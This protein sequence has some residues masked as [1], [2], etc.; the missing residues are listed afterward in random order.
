MQARAMRGLIIGLVSGA[1]ERLGGAME[2]LVSLFAL[3]VMAVLFTAIAQGQGETGALATDYPDPHCS[4]PEVKLIKPAYT[5][6][7]NV[8][9]SGPVGSYNQK[10]KLYNREARDY[11]ACMHAYIGNANAELKRV[12]TDAN[13]RIHQITDAANARLK[14]IESKISAAV[15]DANQVSQDEAE[16]HKK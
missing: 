16:M 6:V 5:H 14:L 7:G 8:D 9:D 11:D 10:V 15:Q 3:G 4:R 1:L 13:D 12:Q 2:K